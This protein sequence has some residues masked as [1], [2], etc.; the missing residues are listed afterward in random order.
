MTVHSNNWFNRMRRGEVAPP[1]VATLLGESIQTVDTES[2]TLEATYH[3]AHEFANPAGFVQGGMLGAM[4][5]ALCAGLVDAT[6][7]DTEIV[8][9]LNL[10]LS[11]QSPARPGP[12]QGFARL[13]KRGRE[14]CF[15]SAELTQ[16]SKLVATANAVCKIGRKPE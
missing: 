9:T 7:A 3:A 13:S 15:V 8:A 16:D 2:G 10:N 11:F 5:D 1:A 4:L 6:L 12:I 14:V